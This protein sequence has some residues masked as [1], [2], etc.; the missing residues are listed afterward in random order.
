L[1]S[2]KNKN[3]IFDWK[4]VRNRLNE[5]CENETGSFKIQEIFNSGHY[6]DKK[7]IFDCIR[8]K[9]PILIT[10]KFGN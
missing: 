7:D 6:A 3:E 9:I 10:N 4:K 8:A 1:D 5:V 2:V